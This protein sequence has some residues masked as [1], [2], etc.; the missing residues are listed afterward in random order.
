M[1]THDL[2]QQNEIQNQNLQFYQAL[3]LT[4]N[5][6]W[7]IKQGLNFYRERDVIHFDE[8][9][10]ITMSAYFYVFTGKFYLD[11]LLT[12]HFHTSGALQFL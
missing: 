4:E 7:V 5:L 6:N 8:G 3:Y 1:L 12:F 2:I 11:R 9:P 10:T